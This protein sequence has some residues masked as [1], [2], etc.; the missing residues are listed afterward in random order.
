MG[1]FEARRPAKAGPHKGN[2]KHTNYNK[3]FNFNVLIRLK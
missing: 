3:G 2:S 1:D